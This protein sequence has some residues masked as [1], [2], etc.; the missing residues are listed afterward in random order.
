MPNYIEDYPYLCIP[1]FEDQVRLLSKAYYI[2]VCVRYTARSDM[3][4]NVY[5][6]GKIVLKCPASSTN[7]EL[8]A[9]VCYYEEWIRKQLKDFYEKRKTQPLSL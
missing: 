8:E 3:E 1:D 7:E 9:Y 5:S 4:L 6:N 2:G